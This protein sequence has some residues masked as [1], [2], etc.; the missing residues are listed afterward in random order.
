MEKPAKLALHG[1][2]P[3][4]TKPMPTDRLGVTLYG[5]EELK[6]LADVIASKTPFRHYGPHPS[7]KPQKA[8]KV[9]AMTREL[10][11]TKYTLAVS[12]GSAALSCVMAALD[13]GPGDEVIIPAFGWYSD[14]NSVIAAGALP[15]FASID[16]T[17]NMD[18]ADFERK[19]T[20]RTKAV[21]VIHYQGGQARLEE[22][23]TIARRNNVIVVEDCAQSFGGS[24]RGKRLGTYGDIAIASFQFNKMISCGEG[25]LVYTDSE[26]YFA[27][28]VRCHDLGDMRPYFLEQLQDKSLGDPS[29]AF[30]GN[31]YRLSE[32]QAAVLVAQLG[33][34]DGVL[35]VCRGYYGQLE[36]AF[37]GL[38]FRIRPV[39]EG[40]CGI[41]CFVQF[42]S[43][44]EA[45]TFAKALR[46]EGIASGPTS[47]CKNLM[48]MPMVKLKKTPYR[49]MPP[50][51][52]EHGEHDPVD[53]DAE[54]TSKRTDEMLARYMAIPIGP[55]YT[56]EEIDD[57]ITAVK[58]VDTL[59]YDKVNS[60]T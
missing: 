46:A 45:R 54:A 10:L 23:V 9:E 49:D 36:R 41:T 58:K 26:T 18:P 42:A 60:T 29:L 22:I 5:E 56:Q 4:R 44:D 40:H 50:Y 24:Y 8:A 43:A 14:Y 28:A 52:G 53:R 57:I 11:G 55:Q 2:T 32:L 25:G 13:V 37:A 48:E 59:L 31:Q 38:H 6:E 1:G 35:D 15:V 12:S 27:K 33:K 19:I 17:L 16:D 20:P 47:A 3:V 34:L 51:G 30:P 21:I 7:D 39:E